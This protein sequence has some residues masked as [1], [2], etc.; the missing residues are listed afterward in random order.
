MN[1]PIKIMGVLTLYRYWL[2]SK[3][4]TV[5]G[6]STRDR[7]PMEGS[8]LIALRPRVNPVLSGA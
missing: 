8:T 1:A 4:E 2:V 7:L 3:G 5:R 6:S